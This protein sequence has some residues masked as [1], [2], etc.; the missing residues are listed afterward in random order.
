[1]VFESAEAL[2]FAAAWSPIISRTT[3]IPVSLFVMI[4]SSC[5]AQVNSPLQDYP[6]GSRSSC[7]QSGLTSDCL[8]GTNNL[9]AL[10]KTLSKL[11]A[12]LMDQGVSLMTDAGEETPA[13]DYERR[14]R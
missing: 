6:N 9:A 4:D 5:K 8:I 14:V 3:L 12:F 7:P 13:S 10:T 1:M 11:K 2:S